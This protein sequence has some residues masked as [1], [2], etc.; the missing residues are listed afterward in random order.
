MKR[1]ESVQ[2][3]SNLLALSQNWCQDSNQDST[4]P[5]F[6]PPLSW[7]PVSTLLLANGI[8]FPLHFVPQKVDILAGVAVYKY[9]VCPRVVHN[10]QDGQ[11]CQIIV[12]RSVCPYKSLAGM[13]AWRVIGFDQKACL[14]FGENSYVIDW[15]DTYLIIQMLVGVNNN[16][17]NMK[18]WKKNHPCVIPARLSFHPPSSLWPYWVALLAFLLPRGRVPDYISSSSAFT[19]LVV[20]PD[21][22]EQV[23]SGARFTNC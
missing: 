15:L 14:T 23:Y 21:K 17:E 16:K 19:C 2:W 4:N 20:F 10:T 22:Q 11:K 18:K 12:G 9:T 5:W 3:N 8:L 13:T 6:L 7:D 1:F